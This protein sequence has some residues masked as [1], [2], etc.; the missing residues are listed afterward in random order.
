MPSDHNQAPALPPDNTPT[1]RPS[2]VPNQLTIL[3]SNPHA[4]NLME[5]LAPPAVDLMQTPVLHP[6]LT[7]SNLFNQTAPTSDPNT[8]HQ[9]LAPSPEAIT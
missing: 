3:D 1:D 9:T 7:L 8:T 2:L 5:A 6:D 4:S